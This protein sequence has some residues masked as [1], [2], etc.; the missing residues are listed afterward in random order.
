MLRV[1]G[2]VFCSISVLF[3]YMCVL[4]VCAYVFKIKVHCG[5]ALRPDA[6][7]LPF[8]CTPL[9][10]VPAVLGGLNVWL[11]CLFVCGGITTQKN[12]KKLKKR[13]ESKEKKDSHP[14]WRSTILP[15]HR[16]AVPKAQQDSLEHVFG[17]QLQ[18]SNNWATGS[19]LTRSGWKSVA[20]ACACHAHACALVASTFVCFVD[21]GCFFRISGTNCFWF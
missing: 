13:K 21:K 9:V 8:Y 4:H 15:T 18:W 17:K 1:Y 11:V 6:S 14:I 19:G 10:C 5:S 3:V 20:P 7:G 12:P 16:Q 2:G